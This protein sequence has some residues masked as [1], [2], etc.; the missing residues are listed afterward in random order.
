VSAKR[1]TG[2]TLSHP[3]LGCLAPAAAARANPK[4]LEPALR[5][6][7]S[8]ARMAHPTV[9]V[10]PAEFVAYAAERLVVQE[11]LETAVAALHA[12]DLYLACA[13]AKGDSTALAVF[14]KQF[15]S[16]VV[17]YLAR[18]DALPAFS[19]EV[20]QVLRERM[21]VARD[22][23]GPKIA[24]YSGRGPLGGWLRIA[25]TRIAI[26]LRRSE[27][28]HV[29][30]D[31]ALPIK[32]PIIDPELGYLKARYGR[33]FRHAFETTLLGLNP[34]EA[35]LLRLH[36]VEGLTA[37]AIASTYRVNPRTIRKWI[38]ECKR[39]I[40]SETRRLLGDRLGLDEAEL[41]SLM[42]LVRSQLNLSI[43]QF[44]R[45]SDG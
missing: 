11:E 27:R 12:G 15:L 3:F 28:P 1:H 14:E 43:V 6:L 4:T 9:D 37:E 39:T 22:R 40:L 31:D 36:I 33:E 23:L 7:V 41:D 29:A 26:D 20:R 45:R 24:S 18:S 42:V 35:S 38:A 34:R 32:A 19:D 30:L 5:D 8:S 25:A 2:R 44:L 21:L 17:S 13:C 16:K 10:A